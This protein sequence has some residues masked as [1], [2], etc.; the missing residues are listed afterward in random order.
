MK[1][2]RLSHLIE[3]SS[4]SKSRA[5]MRI[6]NRFGVVVASSWPGLYS[7]PYGGRND[8]ILSLSFEFLSRKFTWFF[9]NWFNTYTTL[10]SIVCAWLMCCC[11]G[12]YF[13]VHNSHDFIYSDENNSTKNLFFLVTYTRHIFRIFS[14]RFNR[15]KHFY[16]SIPLATT[17]RRDNLKYKS[18]S[19][20][21]SDNL[22]ARRL[23]LAIF[24][25]QNLY[26][27]N[28]RISFSFFLRKFLAFN[29]HLDAWFMQRK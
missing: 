20:S 11:V 28:I 13:I 22:R 17:D 14:N 24:S 18:G 15:F 8:M 9:R 7:N 26:V 19:G 1:M 2:T 10:C 4:G 27:N 3:K 25:Q 12:R 23:M 16:Y 21:D 6:S 5:S 29:V